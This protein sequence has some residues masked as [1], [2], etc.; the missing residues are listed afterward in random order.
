MALSLWRPQGRVAQCDRWI[1][2]GG[3]GATCL[4]GSGLVEG[5][6]VGSH[7]EVSAMSKT[8]GASLS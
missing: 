1:R 8:P 2:R 3:E 6:H 4:E 5:V 7:V